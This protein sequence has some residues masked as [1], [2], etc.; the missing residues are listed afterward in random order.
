MT[1]F[2]YYYFSLALLFVLSLSSLYFLNSA[3]GHSMSQL[4]DSNDN[5]ANKETD[6]TVHNVDSSGV[7]EQKMKKSNQEN[8]MPNVTIFNYLIQKGI[9]ALPVM[10]LKDYIPFINRNQN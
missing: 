2:H 7:S 10:R 4:Q 1:K 8:Y 6:E 3:A 5:V 9:E